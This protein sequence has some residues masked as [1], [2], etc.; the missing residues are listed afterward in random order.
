MQRAKQ[1]TTEVAAESMARLRRAAAALGIYDL[2]ADRFVEGKQGNLIWL[3]EMNQFFNYQ[4]SRGNNKYR[5][6]RKGVRVR[7][8]SSENRATFTGSSAVG[9]DMCL[10]DPQMIFASET[11]ST[12][13]AQEC[14]RDFPFMTFSNTEKGVQIGQT[15]LDWLLAIEAQARHNGVEGPI[16]FCTD[17]HASRFFTQVYF[18]VLVGTDS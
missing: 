3:D 15:F 8:A 10:Y 9:F 1:C 12:H 11:L 13:M 6:G 18:C 7:E 17:G 16:L 14:V 2:E 5:T 4:L